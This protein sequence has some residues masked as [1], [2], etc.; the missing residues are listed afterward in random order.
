MASADD[1]G[2]IKGAVVN[3]FEKYNMLQSLHN[4]TP[5]LGDSGV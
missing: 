1:F 2:S 4:F 5:P 3:I